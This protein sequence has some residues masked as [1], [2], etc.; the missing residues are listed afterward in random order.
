MP[1]LTQLAAPSPFVQAVLLISWDHTLGPLVEHV[2]DT[3]LR[4]F[5]HHNNHQSVRE[6]EKHF[7][8]P[9][10]PQPQPQQQQQQQP[11]NASKTSR[12]ALSQNS[13]TNAPQLARTEKQPVTAT[14]AKT[15]TT[16]VK[17]LVPSVL[18]ITTAGSNDE[19]F[20]SILSSSSA[21]SISFSDTN[22]SDSQIG[23]DIDTK[24]TSNNEDLVKSSPERRSRKKEDMELRRRARLE[25]KK[26]LTGKLPE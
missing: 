24:H 14:A 26:A 13:P 6:E 9:S 17:H 3:Q 11:K 1:Y 10:Q 23:S 15:T 5:P 19:P 7:K 21:I 8:E 18:P 16:S 25:K 2:W 20:G 22:K 4:L 12:S